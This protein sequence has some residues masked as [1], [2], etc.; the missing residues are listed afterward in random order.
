MNSSLSL[1]TV[2]Q[3]YTDPCNQRTV[4]QQVNNPLIIHQDLK[5]IIQRT[6][7][8]RALSLCWTCFGAESTAGSPPAGG[9][10]LPSGAAERL[11]S[12]DGH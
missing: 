12:E 10:T 11:P 8:H 6:I 3:K 5:F 7:Q 4:E 9:A 2:I 1:A